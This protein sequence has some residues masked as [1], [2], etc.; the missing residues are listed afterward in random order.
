MKTRL[1]II[2]AILSVM[3]V[4]ICAWAESVPEADRDSHN[5]FSGDLKGF[6][7]PAEISFVDL[8][9]CTAEYKT[10]E[11]DSLKS[12][13]AKYW[14][15][16]AK[17]QEVVLNAITKIAREKKYDIVCEK[18]YLAKF[19]IKATD[20]TDF[21]KQELTGGSAPAKKITNLDSANVDDIKSKIKSQLLEK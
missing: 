21:I 5:V 16:M 11:K 19:D 8:V 1:L 2:V 15:L 13:D 12:T 7:K 17:A 18:G 10:I 9:K 3:M 14:I 20:I 4:P 6:S